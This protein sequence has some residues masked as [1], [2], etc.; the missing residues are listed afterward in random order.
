[1]SDRVKSELA[2]TLELTG[3]TLTDIGLD[4]FLAELAAYLEADVVVALKRCRRECK[5][6]ISLADV[7]D[8]L[9]GTLGAEAAWALALKH[10]IYDEDA[11]VIVPVAV[12]DSFPFELWPDSI[13]AR[14][15]FKERYTDNK[16]KSPPGQMFI[17]LGHDVNARESVIRE[18]V[19]DGRLTTERAASMLGY[20]EEPTVPRLAARDS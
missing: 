12:F 3:S 11:T 2:V 20:E 7:L 17:S 9:P 15:A 4:A 13:A 8:R 5:Y 16:A 19:S 10:R 14:M 18:A 6:R 1:M